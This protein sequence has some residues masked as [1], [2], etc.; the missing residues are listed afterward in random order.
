[1]KR[2]YNK[3]QHCGGGRRYITD[4]PREIFSESHAVDV[5]IAQA[6]F[7]VKHLPKH[8]PGWKGP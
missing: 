3:S 8:P 2:N 6:A 1:V 7:D 4:T 5:A